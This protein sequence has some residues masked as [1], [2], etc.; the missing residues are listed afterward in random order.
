MSKAL[1]PR[2]AGHSTYDKE[3]MAILEALKKWKHYFSA[4]SLVIMTNQQSLKYIQ[5]QR[6]T[7]SIQH[8]LLVK[9]LGYNYTIEYKKGKENKVVDALSRVKHNLLTILYL[10]G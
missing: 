3:A 10:Y 7:E 5:D 8:K 4:S 9:L 6:L 1:G 2:F